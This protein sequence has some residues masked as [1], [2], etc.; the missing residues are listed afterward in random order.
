M[1]QNGSGIYG[2][3]IMLVIMILILYFLYIR[4]QK[5][6]DKEYT[7][8]RDSLK[9]GDVVITI[10]GIVG[11]ITSIKEDVLTLETGNDKNKVRVKKWAVKE[12]EN[13]QQN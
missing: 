3:I 2:P 5:K 7:K 6:R 8:M 10:G 13:L 12:V 9:V 4:P 11:I 1:D